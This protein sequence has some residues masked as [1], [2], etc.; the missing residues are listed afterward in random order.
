MVSEP[1]VF[2]MFYFSIEEYSRVELM[3]G[4]LKEN[5]YLASVPAVLDEYIKSPYVS[6]RIAGGEICGSG[7]RRND[8]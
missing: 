6:G 8:R 4:F 2:S 1:C 7:K 3:A 5:E